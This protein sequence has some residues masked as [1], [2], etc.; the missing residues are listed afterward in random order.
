MSDWQQELKKLM[1][2]VVTAGV[3]ATMDGITRM[4]VGPKLEKKL[5]RPLTEWDWQ[6]YWEE[7]VN[8][9][10]FLAW[11]N[12]FIQRYRQLLDRQRIREFVWE[13]DG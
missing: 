7:E 13:E 4:M 11:V 2:L 1:P 10:N 9:Q 12:A 3:V 6:A 5:G 8:K